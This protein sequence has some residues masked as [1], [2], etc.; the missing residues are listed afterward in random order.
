[1]K[2]RELAAAF[3]GALLLAGCATPTRPSE[4]AAAFWSGR[5]AL[6]VEDRPSQ[7]FSALF[8]LR[9]NAGAGEL[10]LTSP[11]G[12]VLA[13][14]SWQPGRALLESGGSRR[15]F[16]SVEEL[17][18]QATGTALPVQALFDWLNG[19]ATPVQGWQAD[20]G[21]LGEG[22]L[23]ARRTDPAPAADLRIALER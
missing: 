4:P 2:R 8:E 10:T 9:G 16:A 19:K 12:S 21:G 6:Q 1:V 22:R 3:A 7:S 11:I 5:L 23:R 14:L 18:T 13:V 15:E 20:L 17:A